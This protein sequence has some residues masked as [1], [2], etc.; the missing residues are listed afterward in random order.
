MNYT[1]EELNNI[2]QEA[3]DAGRAA[4]DAA[5]ARNGNSDWDACGFAWVNLYNIKGNTRLGRA[6]KALGVR[7]EYGSRAF[8]FNANSCYTGQSISIKEAACDA[9]C[10]V[11]RRYGF[12]AY[13]G[14]RLD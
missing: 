6:L 14:S 1:A 9:M 8:H 3:T 10:T 12:T 4:A 2:I 5:Y 7:Q 13:V 11:F